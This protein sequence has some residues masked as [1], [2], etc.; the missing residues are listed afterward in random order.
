MKSFSPIFLFHFSNLHQVL[1]ILRKIMIVIT[2]VFPKLKTDKD[3]V[4][5]MSKKPCF[6]I[7]FGSQHLKGLQTLVKVKPA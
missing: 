1:N 6:R 3:M 4:R 5:E 2:N 7:P